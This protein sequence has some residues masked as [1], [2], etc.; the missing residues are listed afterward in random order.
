MDRGV[1]CGPVERRYRRERRDPQALFD[2][3]PLNRVVT[4]RAIHD[5][6][7]LFRRVA[8][9][10]GELEETAGVT[11]RGDVRGGQ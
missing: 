5:Q 11:Q 10:P 9:A 8:Q 2:L 6:G 3:R 7:N 1:K 4:G